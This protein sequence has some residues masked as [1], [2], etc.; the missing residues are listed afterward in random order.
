MTF[1]IDCAEAILDANPSPS[2]AARTKSPDKDNAI[3][4]RII[5]LF[6]IVV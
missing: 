2:A 4:T 6:I 5:L 3:T 1:G